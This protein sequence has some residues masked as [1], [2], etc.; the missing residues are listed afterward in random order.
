M[1]LGDFDRVVTIEAASESESATG[2]PVSGKTWAA[3]SGGSD[4]YASR[5]DMPPAEAVAGSEIVTIS[6]AEYRLYWIDGVTEG[7]RLVDDGVAH[8]IVGVQE[9]SLIHI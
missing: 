7:M 1:R 6:K 8:D 5:R 9:L 3:I 4:L 2:D